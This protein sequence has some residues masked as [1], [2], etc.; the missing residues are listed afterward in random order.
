VPD[1]ARGQ[2]GLRSGQRGSSLYISNYVGRGH[3]DGGGHPGDLQPS[4][5]HRLTLLRAGFRATA[6]LTTASK[7][8]QNWHFCAAQPGEP[9]IDRQRLLGAGA[10][11][12]AGERSREG[13]V[14]KTTIG[15]YKTECVRDGSPFRAGPLATLTDLEDATSAWVH[16]YNTARLMHRLGRRPPPAADAEAAYWN[17]PATVTTDRRQP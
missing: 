10:V 3:R 13:E 4:E 14:A 7:P 1:H 5:P 8:R 9:F 17:A 12:K 15:L 2:P 11:S 6:S 16:W